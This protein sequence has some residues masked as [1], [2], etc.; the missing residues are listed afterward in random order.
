MT[1]ASSLAP[2][3]S[4][5]VPHYNDLERLDRCL[6]AIS[7]Q[8]MP[9]DAFEIIVADNNSPCGMAAVERA[10]AG[11]ARIVTAMT[12]GA[13]PARNAGAEAAQGK[14]L[15]FTDSD[16]VPAPEWLERGVAALGQGADFLGGGMTVLVPGGRPMS[17]AE[18]FETVFAFDNERYVKRL[19]FTVTANLF[20][21][22]DLFFKVGPFRTAV[23]EDNEWCW[24]ARN[25]GYS[26]G[27]AAD[28]IVGH[29]ARADWAQLKGK[30]RRI[31][32]ER[33]A[34]SRD[35]GGS[36][37][38]WIAKTWLELPAIPVHALRILTDRRVPSFGERL[39]ALGTLAAIRLWRF[40]EGHRIVLRGGGHHA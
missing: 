15:A 29:P 9:R 8:T 20:C 14:I 31:C 23:S 1:S 21:P 6:A 18:A 10:V 16:C 32:A 19:H 7:K 12:P 27:Y 39:S 2:G 33:Y 34:L 38:K 13:G 40:V 36:A 3:I 17:G 30:W 11:R 26:I 24:R 37:L 35:G 22:R 5:V 4:V 25:M 28:A